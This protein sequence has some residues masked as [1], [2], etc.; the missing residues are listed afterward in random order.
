MT[1][2]R[3]CRKSLVYDFACL[4]VAIVLNITIK[5]IKPLKNQQVMVYSSD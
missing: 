2:L 5:T 3:K 4:T 1:I